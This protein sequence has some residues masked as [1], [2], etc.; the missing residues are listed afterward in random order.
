VAVAIPDG[1]ISPVVRNADR[2]G[3]VAIAQEVRELAGRA[4]E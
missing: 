1:L 2:K 3:L 4:R